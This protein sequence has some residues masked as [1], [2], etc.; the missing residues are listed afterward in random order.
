MAH[1]DSNRRRCGGGK[2][3]IPL[4]IIAAIAALV[5]CGKWRERFFAGE[6]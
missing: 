3:I 4:L 5:G 2:W 1:C 6:A